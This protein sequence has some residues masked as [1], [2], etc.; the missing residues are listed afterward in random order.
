MISYCMVIKKEKKTDLLTARRSF[1]FFLF[2]F[3][4]SIFVFVACLF[5]FLVFLFSRRIV[6]VKRGC[7]SNHSCRVWP[8]L[9]HQYI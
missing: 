4:L 5:F 7:Y 6:K 8:N 3:F 2:S 1:E 9:S